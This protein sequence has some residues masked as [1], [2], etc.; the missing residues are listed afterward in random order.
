MLAVGCQSGYY[1]KNATISFHKFPKD[2]DLCNT[3]LQ[4]IDRTNFK[5][6]NNTKLCSKHFSAIN[7]VSERKDTN[8]TRKKKNYDLEKRYLKPD[9]AG[10]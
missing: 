8:F 4:A 3:W 1:E 10:I 9:A 7:F 5:P 2:L 6:S